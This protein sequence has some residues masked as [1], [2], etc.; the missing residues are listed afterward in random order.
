MDMDSQPA[1]TAARFLGVCEI[2]TRWG[3][4][5]R[6]VKGW[7]ERGDLVAHNFSLPN[8]RPRYKISPD[9]LATFEDQRRVPIQRHSKR[10]RQRPKRELRY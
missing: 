10:T 5:T 9:S 4:D 6:T 8:M 7:I 2:A 1:A 3:V